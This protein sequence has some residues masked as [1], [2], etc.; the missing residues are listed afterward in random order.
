LI[1]CTHRPWVAGLGYRGSAGVCWIRISEKIF[2]ISFFYAKL[3]CVRQIKTI[4]PGT[5]HVKLFTIRGYK[6]G[7]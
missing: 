1:I 7:G 2:K 3:N 4:F 6:I 5:G